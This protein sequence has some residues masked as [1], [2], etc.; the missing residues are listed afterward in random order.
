MNVP[1]E[2]RKWL[3]I[4]PMWSNDS[5]KTTNPNTSVREGNREAFNYTEHDAI[6]WPTRGKYLANPRPF[7]HT[8]RFPDL[9]AL[10]SMLRWLSP[11]VSVR[12][13]SVY[14]SKLVALHISQYTEHDR[15]EGRKR[16]EAG[17]LY[18]YHDKACHLRVNID[19]WFIYKQL[20][21]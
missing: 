17:G 6:V 10:R 15:P 18:V 21:I 1:T 5:A 9:Y 13:V 16:A 14:Y 8:P 20:N 2:R 7:P 12:S 4:L 3:S 11:S 19:Q